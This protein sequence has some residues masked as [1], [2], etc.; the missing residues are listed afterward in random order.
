GHAA[1]DDDAFTWLPA[2]AR[3]NG[4]FPVED[5]PLLTNTGRRI[6]CA[7]LQLRSTTDGNPA[8]LNISSTDGLT[9][10]WN[11]EPLELNESTTVILKQGV[12]I[13][14]FTISPETAP[15]ELK[16]ILNEASADVQFVP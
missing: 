15:D 9:A 12:N 5:V 16:L 6:G 14:T 3:V 10:W 7:R 11:G 13:L 1:S 8:T 2:Y 4:N